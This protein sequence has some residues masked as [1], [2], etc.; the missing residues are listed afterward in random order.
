MRVGDI[1]GCVMM[2]TSVLFLVFCMGI[3]ASC[4]SQERRPTY[5]DAYDL[6][7]TMQDDSTVVY[8]WRGNAAYANYAFPAFIKDVNHNL[9]AMRYMKGFPYN[10]HLRTEFEQRILLPNNKL[11]EAF[12]EFEGKGESIRLATITLDAIDGQENILFSD[13]LK[14]SPD[15]V[16]SSTSQS[17]NLANAE[18]LNI[19]INVA[20]EIDKDAY[21]AFSK[22]NVHIDGKPIDS[23]PVRTLSPLTVSKET[24]YISINSE[25]NIEFEQISEIYN[26]KIIALG[27]SMHGNHG[28]SKL[29]HQIIIQ[30]VERLNCKLVLLE[31]PMENTLAYNRFIQ[32]MDYQ[33]DSS[34]TLNSLTTDLL[35]N[36]RSYNS[37]KAKDERVNLYGIDYNPNISSTQNST[38]AIFDFITALNQEM[39]LPEVDQFALLLMEEDFPNA[40][41]F[42]DAYGYKLNELLT[43]DEIESIVHILRVS[44]QMGRDR[45]ERMEKRDY[46]MFLNAKFL[47]DKFAKDKDVKTIIYEHAAHINPI[48]TYPAVPCTPFGRYMHDEYSE[49]Y[50]PLLLLV[51]TGESRVYEG[52]F[53]V[54]NKLLI[55]PPENSIEY[56]L[57]NSE[58]NTFY[59]PLT[60]DFDKLML[61]RYK[62]NRHIAQEFFPF[63]LYQRYKGIFYIN[64]ADNESS[65]EN[66]IS[67]DEAAEKHI[68]IIKNREKI[69]EEIKKR[70][71]N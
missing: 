58:I 39:Q 6:H 51:G 10:N 42:L 22:L 70:I 1:Q 24:K 40:I 53:N 8:S 54:K 43:T 17:I 34:I 46:V 26:K 61:S 31:I 65:E 59:T 63:N 48:S 18:L 62:G 66:D 49:N 67:F 64:N 23:Y 56:Y 52:A 25:D 68:V 7:F 16:L 14:F 38:L 37:D 19:R 35:N 5:L 4:A 33:L 44:Q 71:G 3:V 27:E 20:G 29:A 57:S 11:K 21:I 30:A 15:T 13:T 69:V 9:F 50:S 28:I 2:K 45:I 55:S 60:S 12:V 36:L 47:I 41:E 32:D